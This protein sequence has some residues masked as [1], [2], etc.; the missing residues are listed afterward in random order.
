MG[1]DDDEYDG[2]YDDE[3]EGTEDD[4]G[5]IDVSSTSGSEHSDRQAIWVKGPKL[6]GSIG[7]G[8]ILQ[9]L[10]L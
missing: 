2:T 5:D 1:D 6:S 8:D 7:R 10:D 4:D 3:D 9:S